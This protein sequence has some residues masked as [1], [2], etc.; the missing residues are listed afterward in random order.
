MDRGE[1]SGVDW[2]RAT[3]VTSAVVRLATGNICEVSRCILEF[4]SAKLKAF[5]FAAAGATRREAQPRWTLP[6]F[7]DRDFPTQHNMNPLNVLA[8]LH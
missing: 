5:T 7:N 4:D 1:N 3:L 6:P 8:I 2:P